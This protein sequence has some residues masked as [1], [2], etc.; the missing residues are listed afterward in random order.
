MA[1]L[2][3]GSDVRFGQRVAVSQKL[4]WPGKRA[5][6][7]EAALADADAAEADYA[8]L[9]LALAEATVDAFDDDYV[10]ARALEVNAHHHALFERIEKS[11]IAQYTVGKASQQDPIEARTEIIALDRER[12]AL[13][14][15]QRDAVA[16]LNRLLHRHPDAELPPPPAKLEIG[17]AA[18][19]ST[20]PH[21][22]LVAAKARL[23]ART[24]D[25]DR[26]DRA[27][28]PDVE[29]MASYDSLWDAWQQRWMIGVAIDI[30]LQ[31]SKR[32]ADGERAQAEQAKATAEIESTSDMLDEQR[33]RAARA[34]DEGRRALTLDEQQLVPAARERVDA[35]LAGFSSGQNTFSTVVMAEHMLRDAELQVEQSRAE[36]DRR[37]AALDRA[38]GRV[39]GGAR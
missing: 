39:A 8:T 26:A 22:Q 7:G 6:A 25:V 16:R 3:I 38:E 36:L 28:Y 23:R 31:R 9:R 1:P 27:F 30:P 10:A 4:P 29:V 34:I 2:T 20:E 24:A 18:P 32:R 5:L 13:E 33:D 11:A 15:Q 37:L 17:D 19:A 35:A 21:P 12:L 14:T